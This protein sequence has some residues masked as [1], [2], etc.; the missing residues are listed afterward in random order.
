MK[1]PSEEAVEPPTSVSAQGNVEQS[2]FNTM[3]PK[4]EDPIFSKATTGS[5]Y[6]PPGRDASS[7]G[8]DDEEDDQLPLKETHIFRY[9]SPRSREKAF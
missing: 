9:I 6:S 7:D 3:L 2:Q 4:K 5:L 8:E 1:K